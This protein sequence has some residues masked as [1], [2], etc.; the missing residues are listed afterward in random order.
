MQHLHE[1]YY[2]HLKT[3]RVNLLIAHTHAHKISHCGCRGSLILKHDMPV[4]HSYQLTMEY[5]ILS[6][7][8]HVANNCFTSDYIIH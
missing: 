2:G 6:V 1:A 8:H 3:S 5:L 4:G 7:A